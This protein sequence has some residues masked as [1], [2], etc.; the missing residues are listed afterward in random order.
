VARFRTLNYVTGRVELVDKDELFGPGNPLEGR[1][2]RIKA[3]TAGYTRDFKLF[4]HITTGL[5]SN[6][7]L[8]SLPFVVHEQYGAHPVAV[9]VFLRFRLRGA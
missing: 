8:Y 7:T 4:P 6:V 5:G 3:F 1:T 2:F 9:L